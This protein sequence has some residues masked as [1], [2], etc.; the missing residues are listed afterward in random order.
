[1]AGTLR[2][3]ADAARSGRAERNGRATSRR[4]G[5]GGTPDPGIE[6]ARVH[7]PGDQRAA[8]TGRAH[9]PPA[10]RGRPASAR[11]DAARELV[12]CGRVARLARRVG[13]ARL[14]Q[15]GDRS[16]SPDPSLSIAARR[17]LV[18][19]EGCRQ[20][21]RACLASGAPARDRRLPAGRRAATLPRV[22]R[23]GAYRPGTAPEGR[24]GRPGRRVPGPLPGTGR[25][26][27]RHPRAD[28][29]RA[30]VAPAPRA[31]P[32][33]RRLSAALSPVPRRTAGADRASRPS[34]PGTRRHVRPI[35]A[36]RPRPR[37]PATRSWACSAAAAWG[38]CTRP[39]STA[40]T[41]PSP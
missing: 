35:R 12:A 30:R 11:T 3:R 10:A 40:S 26:P 1:M 38:W 5:R 6:P 21:F 31:R 9:G 16:C 13:R 34:P 17:G 4:P 2:P 14:R 22:D 7:D 39:G 15:R 19:A 41:G 23:A 37:S 29:R 25:R 20:A 18:G 36:R 24:G 28:R 33:S 8:R 27:R 32:R